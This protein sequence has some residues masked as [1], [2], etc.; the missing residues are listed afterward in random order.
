MKI[1]V[2]VSLIFAGVLILVGMTALSMGRLAES[3]GKTALAEKRR[4]Q[5]LKL[6]DHLR[7]TSDDLT[8]MARAYVVTGNPVFERHFNTIL[9]I[10][11]GS[12]PRP[13]GYDGI[14]WDFVTAGGP[15]PAPPGK[16]VSLLKL[17]RQMGM[18]DGELG[19]LKEAEERSNA[20][21]GI[22]KQAF[23]AMKGL[24]EDEGGNL[25]VPG[26]PDPEKA[27]ALLHGDAYHREKSVI[28]APIQEFFDMVDHRTRRA[29]EENRKAGLFYTRVAYLFLVAAFLFA[30]FGMGHLRKR[31]VGPVLS[32]SGAAERIASGGVGGRVRVEENDEIGDLAR[33]F[34]DMS[35]NLEKTISRLSA[36]KAALDEH[37]AVA[38]SDSEG[39]VRHAN[40]GF[41]SLCGVAGKD[42]VC[43]M[44]QILENHPDS[45]K[46]MER[47]KAGKAWRGE[48]VIHKKGGGNHW[49]LASVA[50]LEPE[51]RLPGGLITIMTDITSQKLVEEELMA[52]R[53]VARNAARVKTDFLANM[54][55]EIRTP[56]NGIIGFSDLVLKMEDLP[57]LAR[58][59]IRK[60]NRSAKGL[61]AIIND[62]LDFSKIEAGKLELEVICFNLFSLI[63][64][65]IQT[66]G[67]QAE[68]KGLALRFEYSRKLPYC[69]RGD[70]TRLRQVL[71]NLL[72]NSIK[73]TEK[74][75]ISVF[76]TPKD[77]ALLFC[78]KDTG[79]GIPPERLP[80]IFESFTQ[81]DGSTT[82]H[83]GGTGLGTSICRKLVEAMGGR[84]W[85]E[86][87][88]RRGTRVFFTLALRDKACRDDCELREVVEQD[89]EWSPRLFRIL[90]AEDNLL[91]GELI[92][93]NLEKHHGHFVTWVKDGGQ[94]VEL[95]RDREDAF[96]LVLM[97]FQMPVMDGLTA[98]KTI[99]RLGHKIPVVA[100]TA[101][102]TLEDQGKCK[103]AGMDG[104]VKKP[105]N[106][107]EL[108]MTMESVVPVSGGNENREVPIR[109]IREGDN[110]LAP[111]KGIVDVK[112]ALRSW[113]SPETYAKALQK[114][115]GDHGRD[116][117]LLRKYVGEGKRDL[118]AALVHQLK[119]MNLGLT[120]LSSVAAGI[121]AQLK[122]N[123]DNGID[124]SVTVLAGILE[125]IVGAINRLE[126]PGTTSPQN[127][128]AHRDAIPLLEELLEALAQDSPDPAE[129]ALE[130]LGGMLPE[131]RLAAIH[132]ALDNFDFRGAE[133]EVIE[134]KT[135]L[136]EQEKI[137]RE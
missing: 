39:A 124:E 85:I 137:S 134:L 23:A 29:V 84:I 43:R 87:E 67:L 133:R 105:I 21:A 116:A 30:L 106:F 77:D 94:A 107:K 26:D 103:A 97:D 98:T 11:N 8:R 100:L 12:A 20:L 122:A 123:S 35:K 64:D 10:R 1:G 69:Y 46:I 82:R 37:A 5:A 53:D 71:L 135:L 101:S 56:M 62:I 75:S 80:H 118:A 7:Q 58:D 92:L 6:A 31:I 117:D 59:H 83:F 130:K 128:H 88:P 96:D 132:A 125:E 79:I 126:I 113:G 33:T 114:F 48:L 27:R 17:M 61:L 81:A 89:M 131:G 40:S 72:N 34:N 76:I 93:L 119:G 60:S 74:G 54:S 127:K 4:F 115:A 41:R 102:V 108:I 15:M 129:P 90:L 24:F 99:R 65:A 13:E 42:P 73:F 121:G 38:V 25:T 36:Q 16:A 68:Q 63:Q 70:P 18:T 109:A 45:G 111:L 47:I 57:P 14:Y 49:V 2:R 120:G 78:V 52:A 32:L 44:E 136:G 91:N 55:H 50:P 66:M 51:D 112:A 28:M 9:A 22:E 19:K 110:P 3:N 95:I 86:S 104:F